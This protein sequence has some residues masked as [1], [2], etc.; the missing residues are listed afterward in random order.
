MEKSYIPKIEASE[1]CDNMNLCSIRKEKGWESKIAIKYLNWEIIEWNL[2]DVVNKDK[3][4]WK[5][6]V[7]TYSS[8]HIFI[9]K[10]HGNTYEDKNYWNVYLIT[11]NKNWITQHQFTGWSPIEE[12]YKDIFIEKNW[13]YK[14]DLNKARENAR[15]RTKN[16]TWAQVLSEYNKRPIID[17]VLIEKNDYYKLVCLMHFIAK[18][19][20]WF[21]DCTWKENTIEW[22]FYNIEELDLLWN[23]APNVKLVT[24]KSLEILKE[25]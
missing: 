21:I 20:E 19:Y 7:R 9:E 12:K 11:T 4:K 24:N 2:K 17:W 18:D 15:V 3:H 5:E 23:K 25:S 1:F 16:R 22:K 10:V 14:L 8:G 6:I 13:I